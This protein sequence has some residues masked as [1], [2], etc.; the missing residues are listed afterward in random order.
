MYNAND[1]SGNP[2]V[3]SYEREREA[4]KLLVSGCL[5]ILQLFTIFYLVF[6]ILINT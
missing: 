2:P 5:L 1:Q 6:S 4:E 3:V